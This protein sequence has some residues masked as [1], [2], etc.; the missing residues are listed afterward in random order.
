[1]ITYATWLFSR[2][3]GNRQSYASRQRERL[4][5]SFETRQKAKE[6]RDSEL[7]KERE[8]RRKKTNHSGNLERLTGWDKEALKLEVEGYPIGT[9]VNWSELARKY[10]VKNK[11]G[12]PA[13]NGGQIIQ[14]WLISQGVNVHQFQRPGSDLDGVRRARRKKLRGAGGVFINYK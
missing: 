9:K 13:K 3:L 14:D 10:L 7:I 6:R 2:C 5:S 4:A 11:R 8:G 12:E 1:M